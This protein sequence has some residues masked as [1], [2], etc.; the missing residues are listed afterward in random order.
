MTSKMRN[1]VRKIESQYR[2]FKLRQSVFGLIKERKAVIIQK[3]LRSVLYKK[4]MLHYQSNIDKVLRIQAT[5]RMIK[6]RRVY[7]Y[8]LNEKFQKERAHQKFTK[9][10]MKMFNEKPKE[11]RIQKI[12][13]LLDER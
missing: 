4:R 1:C 10:Y 2:V 11:T 13:S 5:F 3:I 12:N 6:E 7:R 8:Y 9:Q